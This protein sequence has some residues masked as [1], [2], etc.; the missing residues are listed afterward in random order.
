M[1]AIYGNLIQHMEFYFTQCTDGV[2]YF[3]TQFRLYKLSS[4]N[5]DLLNSCQNV[6]AKRKTPENNSFPQMFSR[7]YIK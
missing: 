2:I 7:N 5:F 4:Y 6:Y 3:N 1:T